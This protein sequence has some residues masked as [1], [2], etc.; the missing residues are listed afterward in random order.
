MK[1]NRKSTFKVLFY[2]KKNAPKKNGKVAIMCRITID[3]KQAQFST[4]QEVLPDKW[5]LKFGRVSGKADEALK[6][7]LKLDEVRTR[8]Q[9]LYDELIKHDNFVTADKLKNTF[10]GFDVTEE[11][12]L[13][14]YKKFLKDFTKMYE[15]GTRAL[16]TLKS[17]RLVYNHLRNFISYKYK[18]KDIT[19][20]ELTEEFIND[21]D[22][23]LRINI[24]IV[25]TYILRLKKMTS[26]AVDQELIYKDPFRN[27]HITMQETDRGYLVREEI[28]KLI[29]YEPKNKRIELTRDMFVF[30]CFTGFAFVDV[31]QLKKTHIQTFFDGNMWIIKRR[32]KT[33]TASNVRLL[34]VAQN[35]IK[36]YEGLTKD[37][38]LFPRICNATCN[39]HLKTIMADCGSVKHKPISFHWARH[40]FGTLFVTEGIPLESV[41]KM[42]GH[43]D[44]RTTQ[45]YAKITNN[46]ISKD[47]DLIVQKFD[48]FAQMTQQV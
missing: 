39:T 25:L 2:L 15:K 30:S 29:A 22:Y 12:L 11:T 23:Y 5:D 41:S 34:E 26:M 3:G 42:M 7:N 35:I 14:F 45:I 31:Q 28:E 20:R 1:Q 21:F 32:Q 17:Y 13:S 24:G 44:L 9:S 6:I 16:S 47:V 38:Y 43:K 46:K 19:F 33:N 8:L 36:K 10:L 40:T 48:Q 27:F 18:R 37:D 4:K